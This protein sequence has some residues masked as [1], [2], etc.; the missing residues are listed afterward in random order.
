MTTVEELEA[1]SVPERI[2]LVEDLW[3]SIARSRADLPVPK[4][5][6][7]ELA[8]R[9]EKYLQN[10]GSALPWSEVKKSILGSDD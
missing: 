7:E 2:Q 9:K 8:R 4:W 5:Q 10:P 3:D 6:K 1:L